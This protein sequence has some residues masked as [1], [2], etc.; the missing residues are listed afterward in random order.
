MSKSKV[1]G[2]MIDAL[3]YLEKEKGIKREIVIEVLEQA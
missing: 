3:N 1:N 2:E